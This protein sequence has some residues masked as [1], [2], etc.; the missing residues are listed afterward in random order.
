[1]TSIDLYEKYSNDKE[2][3][4]SEGIKEGIYQANEENKARQDFEWY[5]TNVGGNTGGNKE[6]TKAKFSFGQIPE[7]FIKAGEKK[8]MPSYEEEQVK[9]SDA[10]DT[11]YDGANKKFRTLKEV[12]QKIIEDTGSQ[13]ALYAEQQAGLLVQIN[14]KA[15]LTGKF[16]EQFRDALTDANPRLLQLG[17]SFDDLVDASI[18][19]VRETGKFATNSQQTWERAG[20]V[21]KAYV[22][23]LD[24]LVSMVPEFQ[25]IGFGFSDANEKI[26]SAGKAAL[27]VGLQSQKVTGELKTNLSKLNEYGFRNGVEG[28]SAMIRKSIEFRTNMEDV[29]RIAEKVM[30]PEGA[31]ELSANLQVLGGAIG[32]FNDPMKLM[33]MATNNV[34]GLQDALIGAAS[35][36]ATYN[37][38]QGRFEITGINLRRAKE[39]AS[40]LGM[41]LGDL[42]KTAIATAER[43]RASTE[44]MARGLTVSDKDKEFLTNIAQMKEGKMVIELGS[45]PALMDAFGGKQQVA[46]EDL[47]Q[48]QLTTLLAMRK[49]LETKTEEQIIRDQATTVQNIGRDL[50][51]LVALARVSAGRT[52]QN[53]YEAMYKAAGFESSKV[54]SEKS[55]ELSKNIG[56]LIP[57]EGFATEKDL[58]N[59]QRDVFGKKEEPTKKTT[60]SGTTM[61]G[62]T[63]TGTPVSASIPTAKTE[64]SPEN[65]TLALNQTLQKLE[66]SPDYKNN[67][68]AALQ[69]TA[70]NTALMKDALVNQNN[71][72][73]AKTQESVVQ[74][75]MVAYT[76]LKNNEDKRETFYPSILNTNALVKNI[77]DRFSA[78]KDL[79]KLPENVNKA[80]DIAKTLKIE[81]TTSETILDPVKR[82]LLS[83]PEFLRQLKE[84]TRREYVSFG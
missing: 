31:I 6:T 83:D 76:S 28:L 7:A 52:G 24:E 56:K 42:S 40:Q 27:S 81:I 20:E 23:D 79:S 1:M 11:F 46:I 12:G 55:L 16:S 49:E 4:V 18:R 17:V 10:F 5:K 70:N 50:S 43:T 29:Y 54:L 35:S 47:N 68:L 75:T 62:T 15:G 2:K 36:L 80:I 33:Y 34:E 39:M 67:S 19:L 71:N 21:A 69:S 9:L 78:E 65:I 82:A 44:L 72:L 64:T 45:S 61:P 26:A 37:S 60:P 57:K 14:T 59:F 74:K 3:Y 53:I 13:I 38:E 48:S 66:G 58:N 25:K 51:Y 8:Y 32:D 77:N 41:S 63:A 84:D 30:S 22:G 73:T